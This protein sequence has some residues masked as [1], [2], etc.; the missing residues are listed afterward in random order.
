[1]ADRSSLFLAL[2]LCLLLHSFKIVTVT[3]VIAK[4]GRKGNK[5]IGSV[6]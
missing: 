6:D 2:P 3:P 5:V 4:A 1:M